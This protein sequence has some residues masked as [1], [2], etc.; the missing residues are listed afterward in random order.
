MVDVIYQTI[1]LF[2]ARQLGHP[3]V[4]LLSG[5][6]LDRRPQPLGLIRCERLQMALVDGVPLREQRNVLAPDLNEHAMRK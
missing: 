1:F 2:Y 5:G 6:L 4:F 3:D